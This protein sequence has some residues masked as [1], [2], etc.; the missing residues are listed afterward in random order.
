M[1]KSIKLVFKNVVSE[2]GKRDGNFPFLMQEK[3]LI[4]GK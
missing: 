4:A 2:N 1:V 3:Q